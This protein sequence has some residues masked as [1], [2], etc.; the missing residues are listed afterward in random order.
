MPVTPKSLKT[1]L[2]YPGGKSKALKTLGPWIP[3]GIDEFRDP[4]LG[5]GSVPLMFSQNN[6]DTPVW[7]N[8]KYFL[9]YNFWVNLRDRGEELSD[10]LLSILPEQ[11]DV[12]GHRKQFNESK[13]VVNESS[14][15]DFDKAVAFYLLNKTSYSG[16]TEKGTFSS[17]TVSRGNSNNITPR[18]IEKLKLFSKI[19]KNWKITNLDY[20]DVLLGEGENVFVFLD[21]PYDIKS[22]LYGGKN[23]DLHQEFSHEKFAE[24]V[25]KCPHKFMITYNVNEWIV[26]RYKKFLQTEWTLQYSMNHR[27][28]NLKTELL[29]HNYDLP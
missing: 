17:A 18:G 2:R 29:I 14:S 20:S 10:H 3:E 9:L 25:H 1:P 24:N 16:L 13:E 6:P 8:D 5:G 22:F 27:E 15:T 23:G 7:V 21:P 26:N 4:F 19:V 12:E 11:G 28:N